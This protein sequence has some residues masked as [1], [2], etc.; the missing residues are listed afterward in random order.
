MNSNF[1]GLS[2]QKESERFKILF[3]SLLFPSVAYYIGVVAEEQ[4]SLYFSLLVFVFFHSKVILYLLLLL[5]LSVDSGSFIVVFAFFI[6]AKFYLK[7][8]NEK[9]YR[10]I[11]LFSAVFILMSFI[12]GMSLLQ[13]LYSLPI[14]GPKAVTIFHDYTNVYT[15]VADKY[16]LILRPIVTFL[17][18]TFMTPDGVKSLIVYILCGI[19][20]FNISVHTLNFKKNT[21]LNLSESDFAIFVSASTMVICFVF[22]LPGFSNAKYYIFL[23]PFILSIASKIYGN[24]K[25]ALFSFGCSFF[26]VTDLLLARL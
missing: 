19:S 25:V 26:V 24:F 13:L 6:L 7:L 4:I 5:I 17:T 2:S 16:P 1:L 20:F 23:M 3:I 18:G 9:K 14:I 15:D 22:I 11:L 8:A 21:N 12:L 10:T